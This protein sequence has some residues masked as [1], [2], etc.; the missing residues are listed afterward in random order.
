MIR[1]SNEAKKSDIKSGQGNDK[2]GNWWAHT[3]ARTVTV[4]NTITL[5]THLHCIWI[6]CNMQNLSSSSYLWLSNRSLWISIVTGIDNMNS[7]RYTATISGDRLCQTIENG[8]RKI[9]TTVQNQN[10]KFCVHRQGARESRQQ[11]N[12]RAR[13]ASM[14]QLK[15]TRRGK[16]KNSFKDQCP[17]GKSNSGG[18]SNNNNS[19]NKNTNQTNQCVVGVCECAKENE[20]AT[21]RD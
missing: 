4:T 10:Q 6:V 18:S 12:E 2:L 19:N 14:K 7:Y 1:N 17:S 3:H 13:P 16:L 8:N 9:M 20:E 21:R 11:T 5:F 15:T